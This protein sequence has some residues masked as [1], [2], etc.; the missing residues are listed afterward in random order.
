MH[1]VLKLSRHDVRLEDVGA[2]CGLVDFGTVIR[3]HLQPD[4][5]DVAINLDIIAE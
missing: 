4:T 2:G 3:F 1:L 5:L